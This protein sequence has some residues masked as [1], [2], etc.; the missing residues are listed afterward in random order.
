MFRYIA[1]IT[2]YKEL[3]DKY[4]VHHVKEYISHRNMSSSS[5]CATITDAIISQN[6]YS[7][8]SSVDGNWTIINIPKD[9]YSRI[10]VSCSSIEDVEDVE[11]S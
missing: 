9:L 2:T 8:R 3:D 5:Y 11:E 4:E 7:F 6:A 10:E 1:L